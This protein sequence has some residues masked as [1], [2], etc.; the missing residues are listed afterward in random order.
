MPSTPVHAT[1]LGVKTLL[2]RNNLGCYISSEGDWMKLKAVVFEGHSLPHMEEVRDSL[3]EKY[4]V[5]SDIAHLEKDGDTTFL[6]IASANQL[7][8]PG[9]VLEELANYALYA[10]RES[11][12]IRMRGWR[13]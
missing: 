6:L 4:S 5:E 13:L 12:R 9:D 1:D 2:V 8:D 3:R 7:K 10:A 11:L